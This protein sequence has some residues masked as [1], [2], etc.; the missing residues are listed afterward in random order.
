MS[1]EEYAPS[2]SKP[3]TQLY[4]S[5]A[6][7]AKTA[8]PADNPDYDG[9]E[10]KQSRDSEI[11]LRQRIG[12][13]MTIGAAIFLLFFTLTFFTY[14]IIFAHG[15]IT[16]YKAHVHQLVPDSGTTEAASVLP[17]LVPLMPATLFS[18]LGVATMVTA[19]RFVN[20][21][22]NIDETPGNGGVLIERIAREIGGILKSLKPGSSE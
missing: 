21:Y 8:D 18:A 17:F 12:R 15:F 11:L 20:A 14:A 2:S 16:V 7:G 4:P 19:M 6:P 13:W 10:T 9:N 1:S 5:E 22:V 3:E